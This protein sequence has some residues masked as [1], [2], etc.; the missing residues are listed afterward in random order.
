MNGVNWNNIRYADD[1]VLVV[2]TEKDLKTLLDV[3]ER[4]QKFNMEM[5]VKKANV[6]VI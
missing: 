2:T 3:T 4:S 6:L 5:N 1:T